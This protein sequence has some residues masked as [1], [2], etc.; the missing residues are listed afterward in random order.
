MNVHPEKEEVRN[1]E[2]VFDEK[3]EMK[4][5]KKPLTKNTKQD[6]KINISRPLSVKLPEYDRTGVIFKSSPK[7]YF[8]NFTDTQRRGSSQPGNTWSPGVRSPG[9]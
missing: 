8:V 4:S 1:Q 2:K 5:L 7:I 3:R 6:S 9:Y